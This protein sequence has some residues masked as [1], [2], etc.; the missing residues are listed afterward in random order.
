MSGPLVVIAGGG[1]AGHVFPG[2]ALGRTL[3]HRGYDVRFVGTQ[4]G[5]EASLVPGADFEF[6]PVPARPLVREL[7]LDALRAPF[8][9]AGAT[10]RCRPLV[11]GAKAIVGMG[12]YVSVGAVLAA[13]RER[14]P[15]ILHEQNAI[16]GLANRVLAGLAR[17]IAVSFPETR[18]AFGTRAR[19]E[20]TGNPVREEILRV[21]EEPE[22]L[23]KE[24]R[25][26]LELDEGRKTV[27]VFGGSQGALHIDRAAV[28]ACRLLAGR[29]DLQVILIAGSAHEASTR[30]GLPRE[31]SGL[32]VRLLGYLDRMELA[33]ACADLA[34]SRAGATTMAELTVCGLPALLIPYPYATRRH[35]EANARALQRAG[36]ASVMLDEQLSADE[37]ASRIE[38][39]IDH[40]ERLTAMAERSRAF[41]RPD[42][43]ERLADLVSEVGRP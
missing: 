3:R 19:V 26:S 35:Q 27:L 24:A 12:G 30:S 29:S 14:I 31:G 33:Y 42:A 10:R 41:G 11:R 1:T 16:P 37:L 32:L 20:V 36:G 40:G 4:A 2:L 5:L 6:H 8:V 17:T 18:S 7:S 21:I 15:V 43:V 13:R 25:T 9:A 22:A 34:V 23:A 39:L 28:G 38:G